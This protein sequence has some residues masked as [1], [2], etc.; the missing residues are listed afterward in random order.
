MIAYNKMDL[1][2]SS[3]YW[4]EVQ[5]YLQKQGIEERNILAI[6]AATG[7]GVM[8]LV[9]RLRSVLDALP[10]TVRSLP[11]RSWGRAARPRSRLPFSAAATTGVWIAGWRQQV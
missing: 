8:D 3:D 10:P 9:R 1:P 6:S 11:L 2:D 5:E 4:D 7:Q